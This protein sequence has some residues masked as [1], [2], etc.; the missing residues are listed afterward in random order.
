MQSESQP[1][2]PEVTITN[3]ILFL[4]RVDGVELALVDSEQD[5]R[6]A[7]DSIVACEIRR[8]E[9][10]TLRTFRRDMPDGKKII[11][12]TQAIGTLIDGNVIEGMK[13]DYIPVNRAK[14]LR[15]RHERERDLTIL[16]KTLETIDLEKKICNKELSLAERKLAIEQRT[17]EKQKAIPSISTQTSLNPLA[18]SQSS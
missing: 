9:S 8:L 10:D 3:H 16:Q 11:I 14:L 7:I 1:L 17:A 4:I 15:G 2:T 18:Q 12:S 5:A 13:V 6:L